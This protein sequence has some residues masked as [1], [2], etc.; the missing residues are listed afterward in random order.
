MSKENRDL[1]IR[2]AAFHWLTQAVEAH[3]DV[4]PRAKLQQGFEYEG[5]RVFGK[6]PGIRLNYQ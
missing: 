2:L 6:P 3:G 1:A 4:F 5:E